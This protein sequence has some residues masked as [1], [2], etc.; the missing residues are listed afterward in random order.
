MCHF[1]EAVLPSIP[2]LIISILG[3]RKQM[4]K[5]SCGTVSPDSS[6]MSISRKKDKGVWLVLDYMRLKTCGGQCSP[7]L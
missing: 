2:C 6:E 1:C 5:S 7:W 4:N 3:R